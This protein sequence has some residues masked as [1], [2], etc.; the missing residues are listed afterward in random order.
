MLRGLGYEPSGDLILHV[1]ACCPWLSLTLYK[2]SAL[3]LAF[4]KTLS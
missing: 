2:V 1:E 4:G 3:Q